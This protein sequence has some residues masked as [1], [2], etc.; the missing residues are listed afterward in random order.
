MHTGEANDGS[1]AGKDAEGADVCL[2]QGV[3]D[4]GDEETT[5]TADEAGL[6]GVVENIVGLEDGVGL[7]MSPGSRAS[8][9]FH[10]GSGWRRRG[11]AG[12]VLVL[13]PEVEA[14]LPSL[15]DSRVPPL[16]HV[17]LVIQLPC[18]DWLNVRERICRAPV[19]TYL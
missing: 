16:K 11:D 8:R 4:R 5:G 13:W 6:G 7:T 12:A 15:E 3:A 2:C 19:G 18:C 1:A 9:R 10:G 14:E 17:M